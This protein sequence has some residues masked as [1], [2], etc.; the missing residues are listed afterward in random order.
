MTAP[1]KGLT[2]LGTQYAELVKSISV[3]PFFK[4]TGSYKA[5]EFKNGTIQRVVVESVMTA[6][7]LD[8]WKKNQEDMCR[9]LKEASVSD[10]EA[11]KE[12]VI[13]LDAVVTEETAA[14]FDSKDSFLWFGLFASFLDLGLPD[15]AFI[16]F[17][18]EFAETL[19]K[20]PVDGMTYDALCIDQKT[21]K[22]KSTKDRSVV[23]GKMN[24]LKKL[25]REYFLE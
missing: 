2:K 18:A 9:F 20:R 3:L 17:L 8:S 14:L 24:L 16:S 19:H 6:K 15:D 23:A 5:S 4:N 21:G 7:F 1:Q 13:R 10:F 12:M 25:M 11:L 22:V